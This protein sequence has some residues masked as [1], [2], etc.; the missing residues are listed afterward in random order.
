MDR[1]FHEGSVRGKMALV[2]V[3]LFA[4]ISPSCH[5]G[6]I[7]CSI[8]I[9]PFAAILLPSLFATSMTYFPPLTRREGRKIAANGGILI[10]PLINPAYSLYGEIAANRETVTDAIFQ[11]NGATYFYSNI[12]WPLLEIASHIDRLG[13]LNLGCRILRWTHLFSAACR[14]I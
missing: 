5:A 3:S 12:S 10:E 14:P 11:P 6:L 7:S 9:P 2:T 13:P 8:K 4:A 1:P